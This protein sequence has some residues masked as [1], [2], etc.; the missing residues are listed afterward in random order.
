MGAF[1]GQG[2]EAGNIDDG[3]DDGDGYDG[4]DDEAGFICMA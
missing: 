1:L 4:D 3:G 2:S